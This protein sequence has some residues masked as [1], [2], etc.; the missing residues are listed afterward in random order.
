MAVYIKLI[1]FTV[2]KLIFHFINKI[3]KINVAISL[4][5]NQID[6]V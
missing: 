4:N 2:K 3:D 1:N 5:G 6:V